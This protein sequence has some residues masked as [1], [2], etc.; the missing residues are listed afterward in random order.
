MA[1]QSRSTGKT[2]LSWP[3][4]EFTQRLVDALDVG[5]VNAWRGLDFNLE[6]VELRSVGSHRFLAVAA[7]VD[8]I[9]ISSGGCG[10]GRGEGSGDLGHRL[11]LQVIG[12]DVMEWEE[13]HDEEHQAADDEYVDF[14]VCRL[15]SRSWAVVNLYGRRGVTVS[16]ATDGCQRSAAPNDGCTS[17]VGGRNSRVLD[18]GKAVRPLMRYWSQ[19]R[20]RLCKS[21]L[22]ASA[23]LT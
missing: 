20:P 19:G 9:I 13:D 14:K 1:L 18:G 15:G 16:F 8:D 12:Q 3:P 23:A 10:E 5:T 7:N 22:A 2:L 11:V 4:H 6:A 17:D 21:L